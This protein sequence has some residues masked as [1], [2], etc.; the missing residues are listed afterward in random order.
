M[1][2][3]IDLSRFAYLADQSLGSIVWYIFSHGGWL[4]LVLGILVLL[5]YIRLIFKQ[6]KY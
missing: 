4:I 1:E 3:T 2:I 5:F 6:K